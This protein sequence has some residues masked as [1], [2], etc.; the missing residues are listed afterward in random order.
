MNTHPETSSNAAPPVSAGVWFLRWAPRATAAA[1]YGWVGVTVGLLVIGADD[2]GWSSLWRAFNAGLESFPQPVQALYGIT[3][4][5][6]VLAALT[7]LGGG[8]VTEPGR[9][10]P[11]VLRHLALAA[12]I[13]VVLSSLAMLAWPD[14]TPM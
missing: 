9:V 6:A 7:A 2:A 3:G 11:R 5:P 4:L 10:I 8:I 13:G 14:G 12:V 1:G